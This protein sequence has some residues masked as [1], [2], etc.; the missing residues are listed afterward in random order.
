MD[1]E[2]APAAGASPTTL[3]RPCAE[4][5]P[6]YV[7][8][9]EQGWSPNN[10]RPLARFDDLKAIERDATRFLAA[11]EDPQGRGP[12]ITMPDGSTLPRLPGVQRWIWDGDFCGVASLRWRAPG[13]ATLP[14]WC[15][16]HIGYAVVPWKRRQGHA[17]AALRLMLEAARERGL[18]W[19]TIT[20]QPDNLA[21]QRVILSQ[22]GVFQ[23][24]FEKLPAYGGGEE[25]R[26]RIALDD[27][28]AGRP[29]ATI[30]G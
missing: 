14:D 8:A 1:L 15:L 22:G 2:P 30:A 28:Q 10:L 20:T 18:S 13:D 7:A 23:E 4:F 12:P 6:R 27:P 5:L 3:I 21:S 24:R 9:L 26:Y 11:L 16:G 29:T 25:W 17:T 19:V